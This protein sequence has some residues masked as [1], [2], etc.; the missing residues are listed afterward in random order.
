MLAR[1]YDD[2]KKLTYPVYSQP[3][4]DGIRCLVRLE[5]GVLLAKSRQG[6]RI[7][8]IPHVLE[9]LKP[10]FKQNPELVL[11]GEL[12]NHQF[13]DNFNKIVS[14]VRK[15]RPKDKSKIPSFEKSLEESRQK[16]QYWVYDVPRI[17]SEI[18]EAELFLK[19]Y[20]KAIDLLKD[21]NYT[22]RVDTSVAK[23]S[24]QLDKLFDKYEKHGYEGQIIRKNSSYENKRSK[25]LLKRKKFKDKEYLVV[26]VLPGKG[27]KSGIAGSLICKDLDTGAAFKSNIKSNFQELGNILAKKQSYIGK[28]VTIKYFQLT[29]DG[30]PRFPYAVAFRDYE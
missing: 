8:S 23:N 13:K 30:I 2:I 16:V 5:G 22:V 28:L 11:D 4:L 20:D 10:I 19:R 15:Q 14:L 29:P 27:N 3:K 6:K 26:D 18:E 1:D 25:N 21:L 17:N 24:E 7:D 12:Y 9:E